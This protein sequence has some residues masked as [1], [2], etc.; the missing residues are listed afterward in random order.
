MSVNGNQTIPKL[1]VHPESYLSLKHPLILYLK[2]DVTEEWFNKIMTAFKK[3]KVLA[4]CVEKT[5]GEG[6]WRYVL[7]HHSFCL[8]LASAD[9]KDNFSI[10]Y[11]GDDKRKLNKYNKPNPDNPMFY[12]EV[13]GGLNIIYQNTLYSVETGEPAPESDWGMDK[14]EFELLIRKMQTLFKKGNNYD[15]SNGKIKLG[16]T[17]ETKVLTYFKAYTEKERKVEEDKAGENEG[18]IFFKR[19]YLDTVANGSSYV[20]Y[21]NDE[22][23][24]PEKSALSVGN[25]ITLY[26]MHG[27]AGSS[28]QI[29]DIDADSDEAVKF[30]VSFLHQTNDDEIPSQGKMVMAYNDT[31]DK[32]RE[33]VIHRIES[34]NLPSKFMYSIMND[35]RGEGYFAP[36]EITTS[37][38]SQRKDDID[39]AEYLS[40]EL[41]KKYPPNQMQLEAIVKGILTKDML[42]V[43]GPPGT[44]KTTVILAWVN[45]FVKKGMRVLISSQNN[46][47]VDNVLERLDSNINIVRLGQQTKIQENCRQFMPMNKLNE[48]QR[49]CEQAKDKALSG[50]SEDKKTVVSYYTQ[51][52][53][54]NEFI[55]NYEEKRDAYFNAQKKILFQM[56]LICDLDKKITSC[57]EE[58]DQKIEDRAHKTIFLNENEKKN[59]IVRFFTKR[60][61]NKVKEDL[62]A[63]ENDLETARQR[64]KN[65]IEEY[66]RSTL[67][68]QDMVIQMKEAKVYSAYEELRNKIVPLIEN[69]KYRN[70]TCPELKSSLNQ[71][72]KKMRS[73][74]EQSVF[75]SVS[76]FGNFT[77]Q[78]IFDKNVEEFKKIV[79]FEINTS[80]ELLSKALK[81]E[82]TLKSWSDAIE[83]G[84]NEIFEELILSGC[85][86]VGATCIGINSNRKFANVDFDVAIVDESGQIQIHNALV[87]LSR[88]PKALMLG[89][90]K[91][92]PPCANED[93]LKACE[94]EE[95]K[96]DLLRKS[97]FEFMF[98]EMRKTEIKRLVNEEKA[99]LAK[100]ENIDFDDFELDEN[101]LLSITEKAK[102]KIL[103][104]VL[105][106][107]NAVSDQQIP[108]EKI[109]KMVK[110][111]VRDKKKIVNLNRQFRMPANIS[112]V[113]SEWFYENNYFSSY[114]IA[115]FRSVLPNTTKPMV[116]VS[117]SKFRY[118]SEDRPSNN[119]GY[120]N[121]Y[122]AK[123][124]A[125]ILEQVIRSQ[126]EEKRENY[127]S[128][129]TDYI[130][131]ISAY[132]AQ[133]RHIRET[134]QKR[135]LGFSNDQIHGMVASLDS[136]QGQERDLIIYSLTRSN[137]G[138]DPTKARVGFMK[139]LR[140]L[141]VAFTRSKKQLVIIGDIDYLK[142]CLYMKRDEDS[143]VQV[144]CANDT[145]EVITATQI[146]QCAEC[147]V[148]D[149]E[150]KFS[151]FIK[152]L[153]Q[154]VESADK[155]AGDFIESQ[156]LTR[157]L[158][159]EDSQ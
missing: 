33:R 94:N 140:R 133:V 66:N 37:A 69:K 43:L 132:G 143:K 47:A 22:K 106:D 85:Q 15:V 67:Q 19:E 39:L 4:V 8:C 109:H 148:E 51:L 88:A 102:A 79:N 111:I 6:K 71:I 11:F 21:S 105:P 125:D 89:D 9:N 27:K 35:F 131:V 55:A 96:T 86:V 5:K 7:T 82:S 103:E 108:R 126:P 32:V 138:S 153:M 157:V 31:Q 97:F 99:E 14:E 64:Y 147:S 155:A 158:K 141:N 29:F 154:H 60:Y 93:V 135:N 20:F 16:K 75:S 46:S 40:E 145:D 65:I 44:G 80:K 41:N 121:T 98:E 101:Q 144:P 115:K 52:P 91:Q 134:I 151:R 130:G 95:I 70:L 38:D 61:A 139:E 84:G 146:N 113:I 136:F 45:Y 73:D 56:R 114:D 110:D 63:T 129:P 1:N 128:R 76:R 28:G 74:A 78:Q 12:I 34:G 81:L 87:P 117:T 58:I 68:L 90:Y 123:L 159:G 24:D 49:K 118:R 107:Y 18:I 72:Y 57:L 156:N 127:I 142:E 2:P 112:D 53:K 17:F 104:P 120:Y 124:V 152:L 42:L 54:F 25:K 50:V 119:M 10:I 59:V 77:N 48:M 83:R 150:R 100:A 36:D 23:A 137:C 3:H 26:D 62:L 116:I 13:A 30:S 92:I 149:C 122:E